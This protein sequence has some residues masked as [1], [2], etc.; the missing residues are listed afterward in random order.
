MSAGSYDSADDAVASARTLVAAGADSVKLEG[1]LIPQ[2][3]AILASGIP[4]MGH[5]GLLP[6]TAETRRRYGITPEEFDSVHRDAI[7]LAEAGCFAIVIEAVLPELASAITGSVRVP[8]IGIAA[9]LACDGQVLVWT[10]LLGALP[11]T[12][13]FVTPYADVFSLIR[14]AGAAFAADVRGASEQAA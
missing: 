4:V 2:V 14:D 5:V 10:D 3:R 8:T 13:K 12:P 9:G 6:Q 11:N 7:A 1:A